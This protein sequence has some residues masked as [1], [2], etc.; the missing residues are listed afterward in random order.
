MQ[1]IAFVFV[2]FFLSS[3]PTLPLSIY[4][5]FVLEEK[6]GFN[7]TTPGLF[8]ADLLKGWGLAFALGAP[9][10]AA[11]LHIFQWAGDR[12][13]P[14]LMA[15][16]SVVIPHSPILVFICLWG[17]QDLLPADHGRPVPYRHPAPLQQALAPGGR[18]PAH[19]N[20]EPGQQT[21]LPSQALVRDRRLEAQLPQQRILL[22][23]SLG[24]LLFLHVL[25]PTSRAP[26]QSKHIVIFDTLIQQSKPE[27]VEAVL[28]L[29]CPTSPHESL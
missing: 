21:Q 28:G 12:F 6:H 7:K 10:L 9:F 24:M 14:W 2:L 15:F 29:S 19:Q 20:R 1:S 11:F 4:G 8:V 22:W 17:E 27:E 23:S 26:L 3:I 16:M 18:R 13:V 5:T 25:R